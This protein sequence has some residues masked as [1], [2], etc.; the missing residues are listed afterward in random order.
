MISVWYAMILV[1]IGIIGGYIAGTWTSEF[2]EDEEVGE[3]S[4]VRDGDKY[5]FAVEFYDDVDESTF[6]TE[7]RI[8]LKANRPNRK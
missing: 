1:F 5:Y 3:F 4:I 7:D 6:L 2:N 8:S